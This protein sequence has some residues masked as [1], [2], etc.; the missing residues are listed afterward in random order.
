VTGAAWAAAVGR[1]PL[2]AAGRLVVGQLADRARVGR[3]RVAPGA[4]AASC[5][6]QVTEISDVLADL[7][8]RGLLAQDGL[9][10]VLTRPGVAR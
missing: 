6:S 10:L 7:A 5:C 9:Q 1:L 2:T 8:S 3:V 4:L